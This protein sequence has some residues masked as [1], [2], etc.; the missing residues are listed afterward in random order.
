MLDVVSTIQ[1]FSI[2]IDYWIYVWY[3]LLP[4]ALVMICCLCRLKEFQSL[5]W[6]DTPK[7]TFHETLCQ[8]MLQL[9]YDSGLIEINIA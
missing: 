2:Q 5:S 6:I 7:M 8:I 9:A 4:I 3:F 1:T